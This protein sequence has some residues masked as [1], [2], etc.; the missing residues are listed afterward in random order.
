MSTGGSRGTN[1]RRPLI[2]LRSPSQ[3]RASRVLPP[4]VIADA[5]RRLRWTALALLGCTLVAMPIMYYVESTGLRPSRPSLPTTTLSALMS[6]TVYLLARRSRIA[7]ERLIAIGLVYEVVLCLLISI[8]ES[9]GAAVSEVSWVCII[10]VLFPSLVPATPGRTFATAFIGACTGPLAYGLSLLAGYEPR[11]LPDVVLPFVF[12]A[13]AACLAVVPSMVVT[14]LASSVAEAR[15]L[16]SYKLEELIGKGGMG[17]VWRARHRLLARPA[18]VKLIR[19]DTLASSTEGAAA[20]LERFRREAQATARLTSQH[21][22][23][24]YDYGFSEDGTFYYA[25]ELLEGFDLET[26]VKEFGPMPPARVVHLLRQVCLSLEEAHGQGLVHRDVKPANLF[27]CRSGVEADHVKVLDF[28]LVTGMP[29][30]ESA[31]LT[32]ADA[33]CGTPTCM[34][35]EQI[36]SADVG[37]LSDVYSLGC[38]AYWMLA[39]RHVYEAANAALMVMEHLSGTPAPMPGVPRDLEAVVLR[40]LQKEPA[41]RPQGAQA[42][43]EMLSACACAGHWTGADVRHWWDERDGVGTLTDAE[44]G[45][46][47]LPPV[48]AR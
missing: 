30:P 13:F 9:F 47:T 29:G 35:P 23:S 46:A 27:V 37:P 10:V 48:P 39:G 33:M 41:D 8:W 19:G 3:V 20:T 24:L 28:G 15:E 42:V 22:I 32:A 25:M 31:R 18:A 7:P 38:V 2:A 40:C 45:V 12:S 34:S 6:L 26:M 5:A 11:P 36:R 1:A 16:G 21:T 44:S 43:R 14:R 4:D 17:E